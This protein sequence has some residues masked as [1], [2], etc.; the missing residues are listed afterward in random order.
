MESNV[1]FWFTCGR[2]TK[3]Y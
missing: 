3:H 2:V 1:P